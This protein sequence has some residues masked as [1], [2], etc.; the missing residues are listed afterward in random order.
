MKVVHFFVLAIISFLVF[1]CQKSEESYQDFKQEK[2]DEIMVDSEKITDIFINNVIIYPN[3]YDKNSIYIDT[4]IINNHGDGLSQVALTNAKR[5][6]ASNEIQFNKSKK[7]YFQSF[8]V[9]ES[10]DFDQEFEISI[11][12]IDGEVDIKNNRYSFFSNVKI[13]KPKI[14]VISG[15]LN[16]NSNQI[17][18]SINADYEHYYPSFI[19]GE[20]DIT[21]FWFN[22]YD[23]V[24]LDNFPINPIS[25]KWLK[26]FLKKIYSEQSSV[27]MIL[28][29]SQNFD[30]IN[31][32]FP[33]FGL[34][35]ETENDLKSINKIHKFQKNEFKSTLISHKNFY[36]N[37]RNSKKNLLNETIEWI[38]SDSD[39][40]YSFFKARS[41]NNTDEPIFFYGY[42]SSVDEEIK[43]FIASFED[44]DSN[45]KKTQVLYNPIT[46]YY[47]GQ[48]DIE[49][50]GN[51][52]INIF[53]KETIV[54]TI[55]I[56]I[57]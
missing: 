32:F 41:N 12:A 53:N 44:S 39:I 24:I 50:P 27:I 38:L 45:I 4:E 18:R 21:N 46:G 7:K 30:N 20:I 48:F 8:L 52:K 34:S 54:D 16:F 40:K 2:P 15:S 10:I 57:M 19:R 11:S 43:N 1:G 35:L 28:N 6:L 56:N 25:D 49:N 31:S 26:L 14:A 17:I 23:I 47:F 9:S 55:N 22:K 3:Q 42:S 37:I 29:Q 5:I 33:I 51:Y 13:E 36:V